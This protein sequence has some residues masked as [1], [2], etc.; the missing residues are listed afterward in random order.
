[1]TTT[2]NEHI[3][4]YIFENCPAC[5]WPVDSDECP[6]PTTA[7]PDAMWKVACVD[8]ECSFSAVGRTAEDAVNQWNRRKNPPIVVPAGTEIS[9]DVSKGEDDAQDRIFARATGEVMEYQGAG[10]IL[11]IEESRNFGE[12][13]KKAKRKTVELQVAPATRTGD[14]RILWGLVANA[15]K[16]RNGPRAAKRERWIH[17]MEAT[18]MG[19][20]SAKELCIRFGFDPDELITCP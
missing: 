19:S 5:Q 3:I 17:V 11:C 1:M 10:I 9:V 6:Y 15:G 18:G 4:P 8:G 14:E 2:E 13:E 20:T 16:T 12:P 7:K